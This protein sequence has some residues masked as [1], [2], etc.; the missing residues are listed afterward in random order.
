M[1]GQLKAG[2]AGQLL[3]LTIDTAG[4][5]D[6][7]TITAVEL[8]VRASPAVGVAPGTPWSADIDTV[9]TTPARL[10]LTRTTDGAET[11]SYVWLVRM[12]AGAV[13]YETVEDP[14]NLIAFTPSDFEA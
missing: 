10:V 1:I 13:T 5:V 4:V 9:A 6:A 8:L 12:T 14:A 2:R 7:T 3:R 11:G